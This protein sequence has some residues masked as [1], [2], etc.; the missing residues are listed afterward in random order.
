MGLSQVGRRGRGGRVAAQRI[1]AVRP[2]RIENGDR[3]PLSSVYLW[4]TDGEAAELRDVLTDLLATSSEGWHAHVPS[5]DYATEM[6]VARE[7]G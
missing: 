4:L 7:G 2:A 3:L 5:A 1:S 6:T